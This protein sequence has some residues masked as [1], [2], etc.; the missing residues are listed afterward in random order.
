MKKHLTTIGIGIVVLVLA[1]LSWQYFA[2]TQNVPSQ[3]HVIQN[4]KSNIAGNY[5]GSDY[6]GNYVWGGAMNLA[7]N[8]LNENILREKL[9]L[10]T[11]DSIALEMVKKLNNAPF[12]KNDLDE[13]SYYVKSGYGQKT[14][15][16]INRESKKKFSSKSFGDLKMD[17]DPTDIISYAY[18]LKEVEYET[19]FKKDNV[20]FNGQKVKGFI[21]DNEAQRKNV[22]IIKYDSDDKFIIKL[23]LKDKND[24]LILAKGYDMKNPQDVVGEITKNNKKYFSTIGK[25]DRFKTPKLHLDFHRDYIELIGKYLANKNFSDY[26]IAQMFENIKFD[27]DEKGARAE[28]EAVIVMTKSAMMEPEKPKNFI[29]DKPYWVIMKKTDSENPYFI[30]GVNNVELMESK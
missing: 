30:L 12:S 24:E 4:T 2:Q 8:E 18:F 16:E 15:D 17:L 11:D 20:L 26:F 6:K 13:E 3:P 23:Q 14:V 29:M 22:K 1:F 10:K 19:M 27:M 21:A 7:W 25:T 5:L 9:Q 28:N